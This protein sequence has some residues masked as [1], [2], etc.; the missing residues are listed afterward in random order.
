MHKQEVTFLSSL[1]KNA[2]DLRNDR[3]PITTMLASSPNLLTTVREALSPR[4]EL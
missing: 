3:I 2:P 4:L 1:G